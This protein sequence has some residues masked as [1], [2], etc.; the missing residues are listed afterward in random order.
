MWASA[1][2]RVRENLEGVWGLGH[3][4]SQPTLPFS[5]CRN[6][7]PVLSR[8]LSQLYCTYSPLT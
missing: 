1:E 2:V 8:T 7:G 5:S 4:R 3:A 6:L